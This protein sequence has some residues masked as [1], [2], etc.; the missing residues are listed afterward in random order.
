M[1]EHLN[2]ASRLYRVLRQSTALPE[3]TATL[4]AWASLFHLEEPYEVKLS[5]D[6]SERLLW[7]NQELEI[8]TQ[9]LRRDEVDKD[10]CAEAS[11]HIEQALSPVSSYQLG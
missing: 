7:L 1:P 5:I 3:N 11:T 10:G 9:Q 2:S 6:V 8:L 4:K